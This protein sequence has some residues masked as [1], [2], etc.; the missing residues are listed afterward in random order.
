MSAP[1]FTFSLLSILALLMTASVCNAQ[2]VTSPSAS[3]IAVPA[4]TS[5][6]AAAVTT[7]SLPISSISAASAFEIQKINEN[8]TVLLARLAQ[9]EL[10]SKI[11]VKQKEI[12]G[13]GSVANYSP[14]G[15]ATGSPSVVS[16]AGLKGHLEALLV[17]PGGVVQRVKTGDVIGDRKVSMVS[18][19]EVVLTDLKGKNLQRLAFG[20]AA[21][22]RETNMSSSSPMPLPPGGGPS[23]PFNR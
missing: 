13:L 2:L 9:L 22:T 6:P 7:N 16:V 15:S 21:V 3:T 18:I 8:M 20:A 1:K 12:T 14:L 23:A 5:A 19:N 17:F 11:A 4:P 10:E